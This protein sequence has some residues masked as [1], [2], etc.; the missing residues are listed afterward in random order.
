M[1]AIIL[2]NEFFF[3]FVQ[4]QAFMKRLNIEIVHNLRSMRL[5]LIGNLVDTNL[6]VDR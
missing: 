4:E 6:W 2:E 5:I 1:I 3:L